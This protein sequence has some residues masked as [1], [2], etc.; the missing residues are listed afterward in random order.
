MQWPDAAGAG[1]HQQIVSSEGRAIAMRL[2]LKTKGIKATIFKPD[3]SRMG[4]KVGRTSKSN[5][6]PK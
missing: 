5:G 4:E 1:Y 3:G 6:L 2:F